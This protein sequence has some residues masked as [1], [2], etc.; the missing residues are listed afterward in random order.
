MADPVVEHRDE[1]RRRIAKRLT[2]LE[3]AEGRLTV[4][5]V[6]DDARNPES[7]LHSQFEWDDE[8]LKLTALRE[9]ARWVIRTYSRA[10]EVTETVTEYALPHS[11][12]CR[13]RDPDA[14]RG[15]QSYVTVV[16]LV[17]DED[18]A[19][20][21]LLHEFA[22]VESC[23]RRA[24]GYAR[25]FGIGTRVSKL[26]RQIERLMRAIERSATKV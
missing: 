24:E 4:D 23:L 2:E 14:K 21:A 5:A 18:R 25:R 9:R 12:P 26:L 17:S 11:L 7:P 16:R 20:R 22:R 19:Q 8:T 6:I 3:D 1:Q 13:L 15:E 10:Y